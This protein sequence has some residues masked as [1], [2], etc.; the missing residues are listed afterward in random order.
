MRVNF[1]SID[2][3]EEDPSYAYK[4][5][6]KHVASAIRGPEALED[7]YYDWIKEKGFAWYYEPDGN[8]TIAFYEQHPFFNCLLLRYNDSLANSIG[9]DKACLPVREVIEPWIKRVHSNYN[10]RQKRLVQ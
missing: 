4:D 3:Y 1:I 8:Y 7:D 10:R 6:I 9:L 5:L 2:L